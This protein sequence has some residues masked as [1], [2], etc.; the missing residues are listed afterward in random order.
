M[1]EVTGVS[2]KYKKEVLQEVSFEVEQA[3]KVALLGQNGAGKS[4]LLRILATLEKPDKGKIHYKGEDIFQ[5]TSW[6][7]QQMGYVP[8]EIM[9]FEE[10][11]G[12]QNLKF[13]MAAYNIKKENGAEVIE[14]IS[15]ECLLEEDISKKVENYSGGMKRRLN[16]AISL[17]HRPSVLLLDEPDVGMDLIVAEKIYNIIEEINRKNNTTVILATHN[18]EKAESI[19]DKFIVLEKGKALAQIQKKEM[20]KTHKNLKEWYLTIQNKK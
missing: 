13:W 20:Y 8:Q 9:L 14:Q 6:Y 18:I 15:R 12:I 1:L 10:L 2:K 5:D 17:L 11:T 7:H 4:T 3:E 16:M 19:C